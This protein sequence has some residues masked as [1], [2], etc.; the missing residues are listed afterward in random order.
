MVDLPFQPEP[1]M[2]HPV[3]VCKQCG[4]ADPIA[5][6]PR[7]ESGRFAAVCS[8]GSTFGREA[9]VLPFVAPSLRRSKKKNRGLATAVRF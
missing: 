2:N 3:L 5:T 7:D 4:H 1:D 8:H 6:T 9:A